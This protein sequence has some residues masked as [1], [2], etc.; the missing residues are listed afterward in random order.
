MGI[1]EIRRLRDYFEVAFS[2]SFLQ[3]VLSAQVYLSQLKQIPEMTFECQYLLISSVQLVQRKQC[4]A[5]F[6]LT[7][8]IGSDYSRHY[9]MRSMAQWWF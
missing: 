8:L 3:P 1:V 2:D 5:P 4:F 7:R 6:R 9:E